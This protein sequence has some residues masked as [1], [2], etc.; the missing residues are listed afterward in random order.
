MQRSG[1]RG[2]Q[3]WWVKEIRLVWLEAGAWCAYPYIRACLYTRACQMTSWGHL[4]LNRQGPKGC[5]E[6]L[7]AL[8][9]LRSFRKGRCG[10]TACLLVRPWLLWLRG[11]RQGPFRALRDMYCLLP[12]GCSAL[13]VEIGQLWLPRTGLCS[14][15]PCRLRDP[16]GAESPSPVC[17]VMLSLPLWGYRVN[18]ALGLG[19][20]RYCLVP[21]DVEPEHT[22]AAPAL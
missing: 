13:T 1:R 4:G 7:G 2:R 3:I 10:D 17:L 16:R 21:G 11:H 9:V 12:G 18:E 8:G 6:G 19:E 14:W 15:P 22:L 5:D 20:S